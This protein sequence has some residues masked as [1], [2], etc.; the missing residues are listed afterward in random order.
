MVSRVMV[1]SRI[2]SQLA[3]RSRATEALKSVSVGLC[4]VSA[5]SFRFIAASWSFAPAIT[6]RPKSVSCDIAQ[7]ALLWCCS[8][9]S[10]TPDRIW[11]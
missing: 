4:N 3:S 2:R 6:S 9:N 11:S 7:I 10:F 1:P 5:T 8:T